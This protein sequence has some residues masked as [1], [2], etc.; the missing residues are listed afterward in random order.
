MKG[1][2]I[3]LMHHVHI[4]ACQSSKKQQR[5]MRAIN[6]TAIMSD[7]NRLRTENTEHPRT[8]IRHDAFIRLLK[9]CYLKLQRDFY[10]RGIFSSSLFS[11]LLAQPVNR[12]KF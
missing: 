8:E 2:N 7:F 5:Q 6:D 11:S 9:L 12:L 4:T 3:I 10:I 1:N